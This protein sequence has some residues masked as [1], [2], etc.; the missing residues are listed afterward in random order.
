MQNVCCF[1][2]AYRLINKVEEEWLMIVENI[3]QNEKL[4][5]FLDY[6]FQQLMENQNVTIEMKYVNNHRR[7]TN[8]ADEVW[9]SQPNSITRKQ[10]PEVFFRYRK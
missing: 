6:Y 5:L 4:T 9:N 1:G 7:R 10:H 8:K 2:I 3:P